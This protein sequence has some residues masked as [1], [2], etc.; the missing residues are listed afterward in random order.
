MAPHPAVSSR[1]G[2]QYYDAV[3]VVR[4]TAQ[5]ASADFVETGEA[6]EGQ[7]RQHMQQVKQEQRDEQQQQQQQ[8]EEQGEQ[9]EQEERAGEEGQEML[10]S[11]FVLA[12]YSPYF[13]AALTEHWGGSCKRLEVTVDSLPAFK[14][15]LEFMHSMGKVLPDGESCQLTRGCMHD[16]ASSCCCRRA[17]HDATCPSECAT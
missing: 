4:A 8:Q 15:L 3:L 14:H 11:A 12:H 17:R 2:S 7:E 6:E 10:A 16:R 13:S 9:G 5:A 1:K